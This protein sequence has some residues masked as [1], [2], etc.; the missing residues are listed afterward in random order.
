MESRRS[1]QFKKIAKKLGF[2]I[3]PVAHFING[4]YNRRPDIKSV[5]YHN[6]HLMTIPTRMYCQPHAWHRTIEGTAHPWYFDSEYR[7]K[8]WNILIKRTEHL[9]NLES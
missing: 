8:N 6:R 2:K 9:W 1:K 4:F 5:Q 7:L 3:R